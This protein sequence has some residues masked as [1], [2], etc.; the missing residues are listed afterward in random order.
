[1]FWMKLIVPTTRNGTAT[2]ISAIS[3]DVKCDMAYTIFDVNTDDIKMKS[4]R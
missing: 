1:M 3:N 2:I 4:E